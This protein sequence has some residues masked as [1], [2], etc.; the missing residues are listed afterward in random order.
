MLAGYGV[1]AVG[2]VGLVRSVPE[3][4]AV[5]V[6][7]WVLAADLLHD[8]VLAP[9][10]CVAGLVVARFVAAPFRWPVRAASIGTGIVLLVAYPA[11]RGF[12]RQTAPGND[13][14]QP[15]D[16]TTAVLTVLV[17]VWALALAWACVNLVSRTQRGRRPR[18]EAGPAVVSAQPRSLPGGCR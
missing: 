7:A 5:R 4:A 3:R 12:G 13:S 17:V 11:L 14:V 1:M 6:A 8:F 9:L 2:L 15:L 10:V 18:P 16:Y